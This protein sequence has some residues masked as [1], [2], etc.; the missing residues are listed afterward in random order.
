MR[1]LFWGVALVTIG[2]LILLDN[3]GVADFEELIGTYW[4]LILII[5][6]TS[7]LVGKRRYS[8]STSSPQAGATLI[9]AT[10]I[11]LL[12]ES[13]IFGDVSANVSSQNFKGGSLSTVFGDCNLHL[14]NASFAE[15]EHE[16]RIHSVFGNSLVTL[17]KDA[18]ASISA[19]TVFGEMTI[20]GQQKS[21]FSSEI[22]SVTPTYSSSTRRAKIFIS[23]VFGNIRVM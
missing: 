17:P 3:L 9:A 18:A 14:T 11:E 16:M 1:N 7:I 13:N 2:I 23:K 5:W 10:D 19:S 15:G 12:H 6:G 8:N 21:G 22:Q 20:L 4:P